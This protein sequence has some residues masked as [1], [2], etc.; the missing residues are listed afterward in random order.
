[1]RPYDFLKGI[2][3]DLW[4]G[5][6][7]WLA[8]R[9]RWRLGA[10]GD[11]FDTFHEIKEWLGPLL[12]QCHGFL[13]VSAPGHVMDRNMPSDHRAMRQLIRE[14]ARDMPLGVHPSHGQLERPEF[15]GE[16]RRRLEAISGREVISSRFH[17]LR[18]RMPDS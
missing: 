5:R 8:A 7:G 4:R 15:I 11:P 14:W 10:S 12:P 17:F 6:P 13:Q 1:G 18:F 9:L 16:E 3:G 2:A